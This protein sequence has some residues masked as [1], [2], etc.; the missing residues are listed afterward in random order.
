MAILLNLVKSV[1]SFLYKMF[2]IAFTCYAIIA[3]NGQSTIISSHA[4]VLIHN[5]IVL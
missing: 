4:F 2:S 3:A 5:C 1:K